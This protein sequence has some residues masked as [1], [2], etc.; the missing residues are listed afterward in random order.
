MITVGP[1]P[2]VLV[3]GHDAR[4]DDLPRMPGYVAFS[5]AADVLASAAG[6]D[7]AQLCISPTSPS[8]RVRRILG[9]RYRRAAGRGRSLPA[10]PGDERAATVDA[11]LADRYDL[12]VFVAVTEWDLPLL[13]RLHHLRRR[14]DRVAV[15]FPEVWPRD[16]QD[17]RLA[18]EPFGMVDDLYVGV[19]DSAP[20][21]AGVADAP[22]CYLPMAVDVVRFAPDGLDG[23]RPV[24]VLGI[25]R[26]LPALHEALLDWS[27]R[28]GRYYVY[29]T[30]DGGEVLQPRAHRQNLASLYRRSN[31]AVTHYAKFDQ[32]E[33]IG[34]QREIPGRV[35]EGLAGGT[36]MAGMPPSEALQE[37]RPGAAVV[38]ALPDAPADAVAMLDE[39]CR[40]PNG[41]V[42]R[43]NLHLALTANDWGH[44]WAVVFERAGLAIP[45]GLRAR[46]DHLAERAEALDRA[47]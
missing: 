5:E 8:M 25:G 29:D 7:V 38:E 43:R 12:L 14:A 1:D 31:L 44:R 9:R 23:S 30:V 20:L 26:R 18:L 24:D 16:F 15:W 4:P 34:D 41:P 2:R 47:V 40:R 10:L 37:H 21:L 19:A 11:P 27:R 13:E 46:L 39:L 42:R 36:V 17:R 6:A 35:W 33:R 22:A 32:P 3:V 28:T 45:S